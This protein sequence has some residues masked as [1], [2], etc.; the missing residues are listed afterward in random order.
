MAGDV[1]QSG[2]AMSAIP[3]I[4]GIL[5]G[6]VYFFH[7]FVWP[8]AGGED[9]LMAPDFLVRRFDPDAREAARAKVSAS[10]KN[11]KKGAGRKLGGK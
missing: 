4:M 8:K 7:K 6:H 2:N 10:L 5:T 1:L 9:W 11:R 3:H